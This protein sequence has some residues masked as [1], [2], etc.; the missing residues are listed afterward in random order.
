MRV[1]AVV[2]VVV[3]CDCAL[4]NRYQILGTCAGLG[5]LDTNTIVVPLYVFAV[6]LLAVS[7]C[8]GGA[9]EGKNPR[10]YKPVTRASSSG[11]EHGACVNERIYA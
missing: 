11:R 8:F 1:S 5:G 10:Q 4:S 6:A 3:P 2:V 9:R 7:R